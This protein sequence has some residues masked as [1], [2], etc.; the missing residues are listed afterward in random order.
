M[1]IFWNAFK[2]FFSSKEEAQI[3]AKKA[4]ELK[5]EWCEKSWE[6]ESPL[7]SIINLLRDEEDDWIE[8]EKFSEYLK[9]AMPSFKRFESFQKKIESYKLKKSDFPWYDEFEEKNDI[10]NIYMSYKT[11]LTDCRLYYEAI[12]LQEKEFLKQV[13][14]FDWNWLDDI[15]DKVFALSTIEFEQGVAM[16][17]LKSKAKNLEK[18]AR[19]NYEKILFNRVKREYQSTADIYSLGWEIE[20]QMLKEYERK[21]KQVNPKWE[22]KKVNVK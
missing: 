20:E 19:T 22:R 3:N 17:E 13:E 5:D 7:S 8:R 6:Y 18:N 15:Q 4:M 11:K 10:I 16:S 14:E 9:K 12:L 21:K 2:S 1:G